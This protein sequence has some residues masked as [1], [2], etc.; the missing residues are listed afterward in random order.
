[1]GAMLMT[2]GAAAPAGLGMGSMLIWLV[3]L[4]GIMYF[5]MIRPQKNEQKRIKA[6]DKTIDAAK[7]QI[8]RDK[9]DINRNKDEIKAAKY[10]LKAAKDDLKQSKKVMKELSK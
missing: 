2:E 1:M 10:Q 8:K 7:A 6:Y 9:E 5:L 3:V 4:V